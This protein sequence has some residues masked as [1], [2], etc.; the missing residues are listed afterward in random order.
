MPD[1]STWA[2]CRSRCARNSA[3]AVQAWHLLRC[4]CCRW[5]VLPALVESLWRVMTATPDKGKINPK[6]STFSDYGLPS[7]PGYGLATNHCCR[8]HVRAGSCDVLACRGT[9]IGCKT[10]NEDAAISRTAQRI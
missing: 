7:H 3:A 10:A 4:R 8:R 2:A 9:D 1:S 6:S 5:R